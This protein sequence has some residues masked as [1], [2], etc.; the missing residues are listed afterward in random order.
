MTHITIDR[1]NSTIIISKAFDKKASIY[2]SSEYKELQAVLMAHP[3]FDL[4]VKTAKHSSAL[5]KVTF[6]DIEKYIK[7]NDD[8]N[9]SIWKKYAVLRGW[10]D[11]TE[12][13]DENDKFSVKQSASFFEIKAWFV[14]QF[15][16]INKSIKNRRTEINNILHNVA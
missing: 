7:K 3:T 1:K 11:E 12:E 10:T 4:E 8:E 13:T 15:P 6:A 5:G 9:Q 16:E 2:N 14:E